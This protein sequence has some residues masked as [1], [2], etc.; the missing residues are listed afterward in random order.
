MAERTPTDPGKYDKTPRS[1]V[2]EPVRP[3]DAM[4]S[5]IGIGVKPALNYIEPKHNTFIVSTLTMVFTSLITFYFPLFNGLL[6]G[7]FGGFHARTFG[8][9]LG[10]ALLSSLIVPGILLFAYGFDQPDFLRFFWGLGFEGFVALHVIG[11]FIGAVA[12]VFSRPLAEGQHRLRRLHARSTRAGRGVT[13]GTTYEADAR[14][15]T[16]TTRRDF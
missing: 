3:I 14:V 13:G 2:T 1:Y 8:R 12:G 5:P 7:T 9:A 6:G 10:A 16:D 15:H 4:D 11:T